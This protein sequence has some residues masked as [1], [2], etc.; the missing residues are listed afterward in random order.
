MRAAEER[1]KVEISHRRLRLTVR[2]GS[3]LTKRAAVM[4][5][6][7]RA[8]LHAVLPALIAKWE[9]RLGVR[10]SGYYLQRMKTRWG[11]CNPILKKNSA[12]T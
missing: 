10:V 1:P 7:Q 4:Y 11:S 9:T 12:Q 5:E 3:L 8:Q 6:W 2:P